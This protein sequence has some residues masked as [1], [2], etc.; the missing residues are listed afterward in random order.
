[1]NNKNRVAVLGP[2]GTHS[3]QALVNLSRFHGL[4]ASDIM[5]CERNEEVLEAVLQNGGLGIVPIENSTHG[6][7]REVIDFWLEQESNRSIW[8][9]GK[10]SLSIEHCLIGHPSLGSRSELTAVVSHPQALAQCRINLDGWSMIKERNGSTSTARAAKDLAE[11][12]LS[13]TTAVL[14]SAL[15]AESYGLNIIARNMQDRE[16]NTTCFHVVGTAIPAP[17][18][19]CCTSIMFKVKDEPGALVD[20]LLMLK[21]HKSNM[22]SIHTISLGK[23]RE[24]AFYVEFQGHVQGEQGR[25]IFQCLETVTDKII[26][27]GSFPERGIGWYRS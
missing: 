26:L 12:K 16:G 24:Y 23:E 6:P 21:I 2:Q 19:N 5:F 25:K 7:V 17:S 9:V 13:P 22:S 8:V 11:G 14:A 18:N 3:H 20:A 15:A 1:M 4:D 27:L 10:Y